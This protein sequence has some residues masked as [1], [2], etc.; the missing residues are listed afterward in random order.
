MPYALVQLF[1]S[2]LSALLIYLLAR[3]MWRNRQVAFVASLIYLS[4]FL[5]FSVGTYS[6]LDPML[7]LWVTASMVCCF[8]ALKATTVKT[9][10]LAW[11]TLGLACGMAFMTKGFFGISYP[12]Y[13]DDPCNPFTKNSSLGCY[14]MVCL[15]F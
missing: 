8:W 9:R 1:L 13:R 6:V 2:L 10:I 11:I 14:S 7:A 5:V 3:M 4:M 15:L 12:C